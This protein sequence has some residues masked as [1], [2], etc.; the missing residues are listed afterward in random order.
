[1]SLTCQSVREKIAKGF[2]THTKAKQHLR[3]H[4][5]I[6]TANFLLQ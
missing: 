3:G 5:D 4:Y 1:M 2:W 6:T